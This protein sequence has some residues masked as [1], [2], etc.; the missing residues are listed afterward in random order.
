MG[1]L[2]NVQVTFQI[3]Q[4]KNELQD[5]RVR[6]WQE[7]G[8]HLNTEL[9]GAESIISFL[10]LCFYLPI[11]TAS[12]KQMHSVFAPKMSNRIWAEKLNTN[13]GR[14]SEEVEENDNGLRHSTEM[15]KKPKMR[16]SFHA[17]RRSQSSEDKSTPQMVCAAI[18]APISKW[19]SSEHKTRSRSL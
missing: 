17:C 14:W 16:K 18:S 15:P 19:G 6:L 12:R 3:M 7:V 11:G 8:Y 9:V 13:A 5:G 10:Q 2:Q 4:E 1:K